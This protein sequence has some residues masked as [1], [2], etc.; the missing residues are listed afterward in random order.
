M[1]YPKL[2]K[3]FSDPNR[4]HVMQHL[5]KGD[6]CSCQFEDRFNISQPTLAYHLKLIKDAGL[7][8][9]EKLGTWRKYHINYNAIDDMI[10]FL[11]EL[12]QTEGANCK[13]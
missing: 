8:T 5:A 3:V 6:C 10:R 7:A 9:T 11:Q 1:D 4:L 13:C 2:F 12:K